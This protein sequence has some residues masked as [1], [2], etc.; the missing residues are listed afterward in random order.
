M[1]PGE[2]ET[3]LHTYLPL[4][5]IRSQYKQNFPAKRRQSYLNLNEGKK[6]KK[7]K[8]SFIAWKLAILLSYLRTTHDGFAIFCLKTGVTKPMLQHFEVSK[9]I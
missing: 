5:N 8:S 4:H 6:G 7:K 2:G 1:I 9:N 3:L